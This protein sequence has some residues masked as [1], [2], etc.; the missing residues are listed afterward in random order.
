M[1]SQRFSGEGNRASDIHLT[2][3]AAPTR[4]VELERAIAK[5]ELTV[6]FQPQIEPISGRVCAVE[7]LARWTGERDTEALFVRAQRHGL[8]ERLSRVVQR[9]ALRIAG[10]WS[11]LLGQLRLSVNV[12]AA[13]LMRDGYVDWL[14]E[15]L[16]EAGLSPHR[17]TVEITESSLIADQHLASVQLST[18]RDAGIQ[19]AIDDFGTGYSNLAYLASLPLDSLKIDRAMIANLV[20]GSRDRIVVRAI[21]GLAHELSLKVIVEGVE[22]TAQLGLVAGWGCDLYQGFLSAG[23]LDEAELER[24]VA[25]TLAVAA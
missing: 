5:D 1:V 9:K 13:D 25:A 17:L 18:L 7:A 2:P 20:G 19:I 22:S 12:I 8:A 11:G 23:A 21:I 16:H 10:R 3:R 4:D 14:L 24:F 6:L 15:E